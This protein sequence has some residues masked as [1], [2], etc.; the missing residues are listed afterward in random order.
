MRRLNCQ[1]PN[2]Q[3]AD[4]QTG[5]AL[6]TALLVI[7]LVTAAAVAMATRQ[8][9]DI[10]RTGNV[11]QRSQAYFYALGG[12]TIAATVL[13]EDDAKVDHFEEDWAQPVTLPFED[14]VLSGS[15]EDLQGRFNLNNLV[16]D[17]QVSQWDAERFKRLLQIIQER[18]DAPQDLKEA[19]INDLVSAVVDWLDANDEPLSGGGEDSTYLERERP[20]R[21]ANAPMASPSEL[22]LVKGFTPNIYQAIYPYI[23]TL[24]ERT[25]INV[26]TAKDEVLRALAE[27]ITC[28]D[29]SKLKRAVNTKDLQ[30]LT[31]DQE[32]AQQDAEKFSSVSSFTQHEAFA[33]CPFV[34]IRKNKNRNQTN[35]QTTN[36]Q[37]GQGNQNQ[38][39]AENNQSMQS[40]EDVLTVASSYFLLSAYAEVGAEDHRSRVQMYSILQRSNNKVKSIMRAQGVY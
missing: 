25:R 31:A 19:N 37:G 40:F 7:A 6:I 4:R 14:G 3:P 2:W 29:M 24:P 23:T 30:Q 9:L 38:P 1:M 27:D 13:K 39:N 35:S 26:N 11:L 33:G 5:V 28:P 17:G 10:R 15:L 12:E 22:M 21:A 16:N 32:V 20:Y 36:V 34:G 8:Q 18:D